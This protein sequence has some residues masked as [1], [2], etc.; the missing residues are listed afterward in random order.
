MRSCCSYRFCTLR[1]K[2]EQE[3]AIEEDNYDDTDDDE[4]DNT[5]EDLKD[6]VVI[7]EDELGLE[8]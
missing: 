2:E 3:E 8:E 6:L 4:Y 1:C 7:D 5:E